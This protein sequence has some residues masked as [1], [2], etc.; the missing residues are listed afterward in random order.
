MAHLPPKKLS[1]FEPFSQCKTLF[2]AT[3]GTEAVL[4]EV[5][6]GKRHSRMMKFDDAHAA[7]TWALDHAAAF[8]LVPSSNP[9]AN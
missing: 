3:P 8:V 5:V 7:L 2:T 1:A 9:A 4:I 6:K